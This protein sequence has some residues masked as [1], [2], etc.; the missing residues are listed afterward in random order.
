MRIVFIGSGNVA[1]HLSFALKKSG[2]DIVQIFSKTLENAKK[3]AL[4]IE[5]EP[6]DKIESINSNAD[7]Y[8]FSIN[9]DALP[10][11]V[12]L[13]P[14]TKGIW[15][16]TSGSVPMNM[17]SLNKSDKYGVLY[18]LQ[19]FSKNRE[20]DFQNIP[21]FVEG[22]N[23][24]TQHILEDIAKSI[25]DDVTILKSD[26]RS[27]LHLAAV[28]A[29]NFS[30]HMFTLASEILNSKGIPF[31][32]LKPLIKETAAK[33]ME[34]EPKK[35]QTGPAIRFDEDIMKKHTNLI[36]DSITKEI[37]ELLSKSINKYSR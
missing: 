12:K 4:K 14:D 29:N 5:A 27:Y 16:H 7:L 18:P 20:V 10:K 2:N 6:I 11:M 24:Q 32:V 31:E 34:M 25:S 33:V 30:N 3:L 36:S 9:D 26:N 22:N 23:D 8:I 17:L 21:I 15:V 37:Y 13:M 19:T 1:T 35:A 28:F